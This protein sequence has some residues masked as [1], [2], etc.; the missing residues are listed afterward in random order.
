MHGW[1]GAG[2]GSFGK[3]HG[4]K[5]AGRGTFAPAGEMLLARHV[6]RSS[7][8]VMS[9]PRTMHNISMLHM[10]R[11]PEHLRRFLAPPRRLPQGRGASFDAAACK[12]VTA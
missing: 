11:Q 8:R 7:G 10:D 1:K 3:M 4:W 6:D 2:R 12:I 5:G 9:A